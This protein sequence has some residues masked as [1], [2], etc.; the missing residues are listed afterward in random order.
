MHVRM[1]GVPNTSMYLWCEA[2]STEHSIQ[3]GEQYDPRVSPS[4]SQ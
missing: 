2:L 1:N 3:P 4:I